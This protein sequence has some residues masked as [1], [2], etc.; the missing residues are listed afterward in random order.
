MCVRSGGIVHTPGAPI[1]VRLCA[2]ISD[3]FG[4]SNWFICID[5]VP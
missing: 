5:E 1:H 4:G 3:F 2:W